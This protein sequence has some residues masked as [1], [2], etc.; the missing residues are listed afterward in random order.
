MPDPSKEFVA[1]LVSTVDQLRD[2]LEPVDVE[3]RH[4]PGDDCAPRK[5]KQ[6]CEQLAHGKRADTLAA[7]AELL[8]VTEDMP[9]VSMPLCQADIVQRLACTDAV[10]SLVSCVTAPEYETR[11]QAL[12]ALCCILIIL[13]L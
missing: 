7:I 8:A 3:N 9:V 13:Q 4:S 2:A 10:A 6:L 1:G 12:G 5:S 11:L